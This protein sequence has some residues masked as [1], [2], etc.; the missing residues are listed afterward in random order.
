MKAYNT[1][2]AKKIITEDKLNI[3]GFNELRSSN[4]LVNQLAM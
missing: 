3:A 2:Y 1:T 4:N